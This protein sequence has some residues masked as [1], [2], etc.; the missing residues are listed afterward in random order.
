M[1]IRQGTE[2]RQ[3]AA[4]MCV[5]QN[6]NIHVEIEALVLSVRALNCL[7]GRSI[8]TLRELVRQ[9][10]ASLSDIPNLGWKTLVEIIQ[11]LASHQLRLDMNFDDFLKALLTAKELGRNLILENQSSRERGINRN[12]DSREP[13]WENQHDT[14]D[15][16][17]R[18]IINKIAEPRARQ[19]AMARFGWC[20]DPVPTLQALGTD[21]GVTRERIRQIA[22]KVEKNIKDF[23]GGRCPPMILK[24]SQL[25]E[26]ALPMVKRDVPVLLRKEGI[27]AI[28]LSYE[29][30]RKAV[31]LAG[32]PWKVTELDGI[33]IPACDRRG[34]EKAKKAIVPLRNKPFANVYETGIPDLVSRFVE[35]RPDYAWLDRSAGVFWRANQWNNRVVFVCKKIFSLV[36]RLYADEV[37]R[38]L[39]RARN[40]QEAPP[41]AI[42]LEMLRQ[43]G[44]FD[45]HGEK[46]IRKDNVTFANLSDHDKQL[47]EATRGL[48]LPLRF[49]DLHNNLVRG[50]MSSNQ[51]NV[52]IQKSPLIYPVVRGRYCFLGDAIEDGNGI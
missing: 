43:T 51:A 48:S 12:A 46:I 41:K 31:E 1:K 45:I 11:V 17:L 19:V 28:G 16:E 23:L 15:E 21:F 4:V 6:I 35:M 44:W 33:L 42:L 25:V 10:E 52:V 39:E 36:G 22:N 24:A 7:R 27:S 5:P 50:G 2:Q 47:L 32:T 3:K 20:G 13:L 49:I 40:V 38:A 18:F 29:A 8:H 26:N 34:I 14:V 37:I 9:D 30:L